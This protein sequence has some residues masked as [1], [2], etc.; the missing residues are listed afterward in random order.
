MKYFS[1]NLSLITACCLSFYSNEGGAATRGAGDGKPQQTPPPS[2]SPAV[3]VGVP[4]G[5]KVI[6][7]SQDLEPEDTK[8]YVKRVEY[9]DRLFRG[10]NLNVQEIIFDFEKAA[11]HLSYMVGWT[12]LSP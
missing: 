4:P 10:K 3:P 12:C 9:G 7:K 6:K 11:P 8:I 1:K 2:S 5:Y